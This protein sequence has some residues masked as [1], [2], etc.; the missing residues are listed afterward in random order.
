MDHDRRQKTIWEK[1]SY[2]AGLV[3]TII[4]I[5]SSIIYGS[6]VLVTKDELEKVEQCQRVELEKSQ[7]AQEKY[8]QEFIMNASSS[9]ADKAAE[10]TIRRWVELTGIKTK[11]RIV[12]YE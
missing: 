2:I 11:R 3:L 8:L 4:T 12:D 5:A 1:W 7:E 9:A 6:R 10:K